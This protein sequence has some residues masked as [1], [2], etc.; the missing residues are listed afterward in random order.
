MDMEIRK[1]HRRPLWPRANYRFTID[2]LILSKISR[3]RCQNTVSDPSAFGLLEVESLCRGVTAA[4]E[5][6][7]TESDDPASMDMLFLS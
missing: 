3:D 2:T 7:V 5:H 1:H 4:H 6:Y